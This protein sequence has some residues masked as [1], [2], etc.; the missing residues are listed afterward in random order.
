MANTSATGGYLSPAVASPPQEDASLD[1]IIQQAVAGITGLSGSLVRP[2][3]QPTTPKV[4]EASVDW[5]A[6]GITAQE[7]DAGPY[8][9]HQPAG[10]GTDSYVR[11]EDITVSCT[12]YGPDSQQNA[13]ALRDGLAIP[14][15]VEALK[16]QGISFVAC[17][18]IRA[19]PELFNQ[20]WVKRQ[21]IEDQLRRKVTRTSSTLSL[22][23]TTT[24]LTT[25]TRGQ[26]GI[27]TN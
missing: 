22:L 19:V 4:P 7:A 5:C 16:A 27:I 23:T 20:Q 8:L 18:P 12:F 25:D 9:L 1:A 6:L 17:G 2:R 11:H 24:T 13:A 3:W 14:Q 10:D 15:N 21:D 26:M